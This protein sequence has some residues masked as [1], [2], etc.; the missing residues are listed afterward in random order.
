MRTQSLVGSA[1]AIAVLVAASACSRTPSVRVGD[2]D[3]PIRN[4]AEVAPGVY[5]G[6]Q[7]DES[8]FRALKELGVRTIVNLRSKHDDAKDASPLGID[9]LRLPMKATTDIDP[10]DE[11]EVR[12]FLGIVGD[13]AR[14]PVFIHCAEG[15]DR[16]GTMCA[17]WRMEHDGWTP[18][19]ALE[20]M[21][22]FGWHEAMYGG[23]GK[24][25]LAYRPLAAPDAPR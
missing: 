6:A 7:P 19:R 23:L 2:V 4:F 8:G 13:P 12:E 5:R 21:R 17:V 25:V 24:F 10:P 1:A 18:A 15:K 9:V 11:A 22:A 3:V 20:E 14:R 16:T